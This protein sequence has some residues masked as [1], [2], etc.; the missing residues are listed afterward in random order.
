[1][2]EI[3]DM[4]VQLDSQLL[5]RLAQC[6]TATIGHS[7]YRGFAHSRIK[8]LTGDPG[9]HTGTAV[10]LALPAMDSTLLH[11]CVGLLR[12]GDI[13]VIDRL[14]DERHA[15]LGGGVSYTIKQ[16]DVAAVIVDGPCADPGEL[17]ETGLAVWGHGFS[18]VTTRLAD[19]WGAFNVP[20]NCGGAVVMPGDAVLADENGVYF[21]SP[22]KLDS[23]VSHALA[24][25]EMQQK[26]I[27]AISRDKPIGSLSGATAMV[28]NSKKS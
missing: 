1:M 4:P 8:L 5:S 22:E 2:Y 27:P 7:E 15:C 20:I 17:R 23:V 14:G 18:P 26:A 16:M 11:H 25:Q 28:E 13:L 6:D 19:M 9:P 12:P 10:T 24:A 21:G 3:N